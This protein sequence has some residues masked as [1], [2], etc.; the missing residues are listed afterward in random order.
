MSRTIDVVC[1]DLGGVLMRICRSWEEACARAGLPLRDEPVLR[2]PEL[3]E[4]RR[5]IKDSYEIGGMSCEDYVRAIAGATAGLYSAEE[6]RRI[7]DAWIIEDYP[8]THDLVERL[9]QRNG[10]T[11]ACL[12]NTNRLHWHAGLGVSG[13]RPISP[14]VTRIRRRFASHEVGLA[15]P[16]ARFYAHADSVLGVAPARVLFFD[17]LEENVA[18]AKARGWRAE[19]IDHTGDT[20]DQMRRHLES[21]G[22]IV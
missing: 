6:V 9:N 2:S 7:H 22:I 21:Y 19:V 12:S 3:I 10:I 5:T 17:D 18:A 14:A 16:D 1:F 8:G 4:A 11:T 20:A 15:K 13:G